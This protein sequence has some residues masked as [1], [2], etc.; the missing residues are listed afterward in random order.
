[1]AGS[2][3]EAQKRL[4]AD[5]TRVLSLYGFITDAY[6][7]EFFTDNLWGS[8]PLTWQ[9]ALADVPPPQL[10]ALLLENRSSVEGGGGGG[11][12]YISVWPLS[13]LAFKAAAHALALPRRPTSQATGSSDRTPEEFRE[14]RC[15][16]SKLHPHFRKHVKPKKQHEIRR[17]G[18][19]V[20]KLSDLTG[21]RQVVD[22]GSGQGHLS[23][24]LAF[25]LGLSVTAVE[26]DAQL[27]A[28]ATKFDQELVQALKKEQAKQGG[29]TPRGLSLRGPSHVVAWV[30]PRAPWPEF[31]HLLQRGKDE[32]GSGMPGTPHPGPRFPGRT[33]EKG[34]QPR[35]PFEQGRAKAGEEDYGGG[36]IPASPEH[37]PLA[38]GGRADPSRPAAGRQFLLTGLHAC[39]DLSVALLRQFV[40]CPHV[41]GITSVACC[42]MKLTTKE[43][44]NP[45]GQAP[46][47]PCPSPC[48]VEHGYPLSAWVAALPGHQLSY[49][50]REGACHALEDHALRLKS[51]SATLRT[52]CFRAVLETVIRAAN[53]AKKR[54][55]VQTIHKAYLLPFEEYA[56]LGLEGVGLDP[57]A[58]LDSAAWEAMLAQ[59]QKVVAF[60][61]LALLL[62]PLA[63][64]LLLMDRTIFLQEQGIW[65]WW[66]QRR[67]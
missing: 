37:G 63:E 23:R 6:I 31:L 65:C 64:T 14:N 66:Q 7:I 39:G 67:S 51:E 35:E 4:A 16:S 24:F 44:P 34:G 32:E 20:K 59:E 60:F 56:R 19:V 46:T 61:S 28:Q 26:G 58:R 15:Q 18:R 38:R 9:A 1:M 47:H 30:D 57:G 53:P 40:R 13:L 62:A 50:A 49:K 55:G 41:V 33:K 21:C 36:G 11:I 25:G 2:S 27:V 5:I 8:L 52:H 10:A 54:L 43:G 42:Y 48:P 29:Q 3:L 12:S 22:V 45:P 17:L